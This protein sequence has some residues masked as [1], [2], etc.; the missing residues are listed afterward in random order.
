MNRVYIRK[1]VHADYP[2]ILRI[3]GYYI[4]NTTASWRYH[5]PGDNW[6]ADFE[7]AHQTPERPVLVAE[8]SGLIVGYAC[9][10]DFRSYEGYWP[11]AE[12]SI[13]VMPE[14]SNQ[15]IGTR[16]M[17]ELL[18]LASHSKLKNIIAAI[19]G[20]NE[21]SVR[22]HEKFNFAKCGELKEIGFKNN[23]WLSLILMQI[24][25]AHYQEQI[26]VQPRKTY[27]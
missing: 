20:S 4:E 18:E 12:N 1:A 24:D 17:V 22:F 19:D 25:L 14:Y 6:L 10:S 9:L 11:C 26:K 27:C 3:L 16:L 5:V 8:L 7:Q 2:A 15:Q 13:Y 23:A 21:S